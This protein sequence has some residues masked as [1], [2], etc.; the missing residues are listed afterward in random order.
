MFEK[1][2]QCPYDSCASM[3]FLMGTMAAY[4]EIITFVN[5]S[6]FN[7]MHSILE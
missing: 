3:R 6:L 1:N 5:D 4:Q 2:R 7:Q